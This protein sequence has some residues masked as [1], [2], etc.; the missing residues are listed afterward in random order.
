MIA[1]FAAKN[2]QCSFW[3]FAGM[4]PEAGGTAQ[5]QRDAFAS[6]QTYLSG[7]LPMTFM[8]WS[9]AFEHLSRQIKA[10]DIILLDEI[11]WMAEQDPTFIPKLKLWWDRQTQ[12]LLLVLCGSVFT[13]IEENILKST[14]FF[15]RI[16]LTMTLD[17]FSIPE[18]AEFLRKMGFKGSAYEMYKVLS[19]LGGISWY[20]EQF[21]VNQTVDENIQQLAFEKDGLLVLEFNRIF[22][23][24]FQGKGM[25][26]KKILE[27]LQEGARTL[28]E[29]RKMI[30]FAHSGTLSHM[31]EQLITAGFLQK[32]P[33]WFFK[34]NQPLKQSLY[35]ISDPY[36]RFYLKVIEKNLSR[37]A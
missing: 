12:S 14:A 6:R 9:D 26:Y 36:M 8:D 1:E 2:G 17:P 22:H 31:M 37:I 33:L 30:D 16:N 32:Q 5:T 3:N 15:G 18:S 23:D 21:N 24:L 28:S 25:T 27:A 13:W 35:Y 34:T 19:I 29:V 10:G 11:S 7:I 4:A 20:L